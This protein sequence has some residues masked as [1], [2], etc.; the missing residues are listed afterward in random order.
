MKKKIAMLCALG[1]TVGSL[2]GCGQNNKNV[3]AA[4][5]AAPAEQAAPAAAEPEAKPEEN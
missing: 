2:A 1:L 5:E 4:T 3:P